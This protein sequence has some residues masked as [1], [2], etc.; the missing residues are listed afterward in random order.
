MRVRSQK[1]TKLAFKYVTQI[2]YLSNLR[3]LLNTLD[4]Q[5]ECEVLYGLMC[6]ISVGLNQYERILAR[7]EISFKHARHMDTGTTGTPCRRHSRT[8]FQRRQ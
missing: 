5:D 4:L 2:L 1:K 8:H 6:P 3:C 7:G